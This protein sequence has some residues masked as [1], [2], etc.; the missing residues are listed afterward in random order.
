VLAAVKGVHLIDPSA[1]HDS[2]TEHEVKRLE[3]RKA[4]AKRE[5]VMS[6]VKEFVM[7]RVKEFVMSHVNASCRLA[8]SHVTYQYVMLQIHESCHICMSHVTYEGVMSLMDES[9]HISIAVSH[10]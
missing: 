1:V 2:M 8:M 3:M 9:C 5:F 7:S 4:L 6:H 10:M